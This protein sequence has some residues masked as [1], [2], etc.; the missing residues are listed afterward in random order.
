MA[1]LM[2]TLYGLGVAHLSCIVAS[3]R[4]ASESAACSVGN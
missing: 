1:T 4:G 2:N 3:F